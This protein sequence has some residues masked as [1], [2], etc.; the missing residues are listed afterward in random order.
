MKVQIKSPLARVW[1]ILTD[2]EYISHWYGEPSNGFKQIAKLTE[3]KVGSNQFVNVFV[4]DYLPRRNLRLTVADIGTTNPYTVSFRLTETGRG[5]N[6]LELSIPTSEKRSAL[7]QL[8]ATRLL[9]IASLSDTGKPVWP[10]PISK[11]QPLAFELWPPLHQDNLAQWFPYSQ[12]NDGSRYIFIVDEDG[13]R[14]ILIQD[15][16]AHYD[17]SLA[18]QI[19]SSTGST[20]NIAVELDDEGM[21]LKLEHSGWWDKHQEYP[22]EEL[23]LRLWHHF[24]ATWTTA[25][26]E[27]A[28]IAKLK[29]L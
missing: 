1:E 26:L 23:Y 13:P 12:R 4:E 27:A 14:A 2:A 18:I 6:I 25:L 19:D 28:H 7:E 22:P 5:T 17:E 11:L 16:F 24:D 20:V 10:G 9:A 15:W 8:W 21:S 3:V 29:G